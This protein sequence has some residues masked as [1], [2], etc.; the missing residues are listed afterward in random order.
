MKRERDSGLAALLAQLEV[1]SHTV[2][3][4]TLLIGLFEVTIIGSATAEAFLEWK[5]GLPPWV[6][7]AAVWIVW[8]LWHS[9]W[10]PRRRLRHLER[11]GNAYRRAFLT[12]IYPWVSIGFSQM[13]RPLLNG[14]V[15]GAMVDGR[16]RLHALAAAVGLSICFAALGAIIHAIRAIGIHNAAFLREFVE[17]ETFVPI[18]SGIYRVM[19]HPL[20]WSGIAYS[21]GLAVAAGETAGYIIA[22]LNVVYGILYV[23]LENRRLGNIFGSRYEDYRGRPRQRFTPLTMK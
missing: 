21:C 10:F 12:D 9:R 16:F 17:V 14:D 7:F 15:L 8:T 20:F 23:R 5:L 3:A 13:W 4:G 2:L 6:I 22:G 19:M 1:G 18:E 11:G